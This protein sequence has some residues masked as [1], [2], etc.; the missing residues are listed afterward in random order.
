M[1]D[2]PV[3]RHAVATVR[4]VTETWESANSTLGG[5]PLVNLGLLAAIVI[6]VALG[7]STVLRS[8]TRHPES[9]RMFTDV[10]RREIFEACGSRCEHKHPLWFRC[11]R[12]AEHADHIYPFARGGST[13]LANAQGLCARHNLRKSAVVPTRIYR[14]RLRRRRRRYHPTNPSLRRSELI[15]G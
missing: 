15:R 8:L 13:S 3:I 14:W 2:L 1:T 7:V 6:V 4:A 10:Q 9:R 11:G 5:D 12:P